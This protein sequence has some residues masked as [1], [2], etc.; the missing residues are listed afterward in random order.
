MKSIHLVGGMLIIVAYVI[1]ARYPMIAQK[2]G[3]A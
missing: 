1:G 2:A 3:L